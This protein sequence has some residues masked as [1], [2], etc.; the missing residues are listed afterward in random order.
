MVLG[1][2]QPLLILVVFELCSCLASKG[3]KLEPVYSLISL[4]RYD[5]N[6]NVLMLHVCWMFIR[7]SKTVLGIV[8]HIPHG[9]FHHSTLVRTM[10]FIVPCL[11]PQLKIWETY[12]AVPVVSPVPNG[13]IP[14]RGCECIY[15]AI[16]CL[17]CMC[18][19]SAGCW[20][21]VLVCM[22]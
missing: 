3:S 12:P 7:K 13:L 4:L 6:V 21:C 1:K 15:F 5:T 9:Q 10:L 19:C 11:S 2:A 18:V 8:G 16:S 22:N 14:L 20:K 17:V